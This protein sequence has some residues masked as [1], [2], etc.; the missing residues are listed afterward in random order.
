MSDISN[1]RVL[2]LF[3]ATLRE[4]LACFFLLFSLRKL[5]TFHV[6]QMLFGEGVKASIR[7]EALQEQTRELVTFPWRIN[8]SGSTH[9]TSRQEY[10]D[11]S[12]P[13]TRTRVLIQSS[14]SF[15]QSINS[16]ESSVGE[17]RLNLASSLAA[18]PVKSRG[19]NVSLSRRSDPVIR[20]AGT[21]DVTESGN[22]DGPQ[23]LANGS[24]L[25]RS[26]CPIVSARYAHAC[27]RM[28]EYR[29]IPRAG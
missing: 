12:C 11:I 5:P 6:F 29:P 27:S 15:L 4:N 14:P 17:Q 9:P 13:S 26:D 23:S 25:A 21:S 10:L 7:Q 8:F 19:R 2:S 28:R 22:S 20:Y 24:L 3:S 18:S 1:S 16:L